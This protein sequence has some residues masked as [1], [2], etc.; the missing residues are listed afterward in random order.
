MKLGVVFLTIVYWAAVLFLAGLVMALQGDCWAGTTQ[1]EAAECS[2][3]ATAAG[4]VVIAL[5]AVL[6]LGAWRYVRN[7]W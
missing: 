2:R 6:Y 4:L 3:N 1:I 7:R 5:G